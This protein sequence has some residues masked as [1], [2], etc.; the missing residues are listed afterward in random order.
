MQREMFRNFLLEIGYTGSRALDQIRQLQMNPSLLTDAQAAAVRARQAIPSVQARRVNPAA[1]ARVLIG[2]G[3]Q[4]TYN[5]GF[6]SLNK[7]LD[8][9]L[10]FGFS[11]TFSRNMSNNDE[12]LGVAAITN[13]TPQAPQDTFRLITKRACR[14]STALTASS[15]I[16]SMKFRRRDS[17][18]TTASSD[19]SSAAGRFRESRQCSLGS[20][21]RS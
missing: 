9:G 1:G 15:R 11:Y 14:F 10:Q 3:A 17:P 4:S 12:S 18:K 16:T 13:S 5:A 19:R 8:R 21:S 20:R 7:R 2:P 6:V